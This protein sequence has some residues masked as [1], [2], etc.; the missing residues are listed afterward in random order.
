M[1]LK[2]LSIQSTQYTNWDDPWQLDKTDKVRPFSTEENRIVCW[3]NAHKHPY[4]LEYFNELAKSKGFTGN[5]VRD[6]LLS[7]DDIVVFIKY[8]ITQEYQKKT[9]TYLP[10]KPEVYYSHNKAQVN[11]LKS[12]LSNRRTL[13][14]TT[15]LE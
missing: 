6:L 9:H 1:T 8:L 12:A 11:G 14:F 7:E 10:F 15:D 5:T 2:D 3:W 4:I 13:F